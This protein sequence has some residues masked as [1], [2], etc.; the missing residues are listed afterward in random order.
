VRP[1]WVS[2]G[3]QLGTWAPVFHEVTGLDVGARCG[4]ECCLCVLPTVTLCTFSR[5]LAAVPWR[6]RWLQVAATVPPPFVQLQS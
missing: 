2:M 4:A 6:E 1:G 3:N 5:A